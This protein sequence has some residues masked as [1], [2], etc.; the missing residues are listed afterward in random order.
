MSWSFQNKVEPCLVTLAN[1]AARASHLV[2]FL[3]IGNIYGANHITDLV[4]YLQAPLLVLMTVVAG[5]TDAVVMP[6]FHKADEKDTAKF[7]FNWVIR[8]IVSIIL[9]LSFSILVIFSFY[10][11]IFD[12]ILIALLCPIPLFGALASFKAGVLNASDKFRVAML[13]PLF[14]GMLSVPYIFLSSRSIYSLSI[15][16]LLFEVGKVVGLYI[17]KDLTYGGVSRKSEQGATIIR[18]GSKNAKWQIIGSFVFSMVFLVDVFFASCMEVGSISMVEYANKLWNIVPLLFTGHI[19]ISYASMSKRFNKDENINY[20]VNNI[21]IKYGV[22]AFVISLLLIL[23]SPEI[24]SILYQFGNFNP[25]ELHIFSGLL[26]CYLVGA[27][28]Y[29]YSLVYV[30]AFSTI[31]LLRV[32]C[33]IALLAFVFNIL[34]DVI[35]INYYSIYGIGLATSLVYTMNAIL[36]VFMFGRYNKINQ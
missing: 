6:S 23:L 32:I 36:F 31:G 12:W 22:L 9:P 13:G 21:A 33:I 16:L 3:A 15:S 26:Q 7:I 2:F 18:W 30:R 17:F 19:A 4:L 29:V 1:L 27:G 5:A 25:K 10:R 14:G 28:P 35:L 11:G 20:I 34:F 24:V 8:R